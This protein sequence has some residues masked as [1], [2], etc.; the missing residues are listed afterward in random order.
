MSKRSI[1]LLGTITL[2]LFPVPTFVGLYWFE[3]ILP[4]EIFEF[5]NLT[6][7][8]LIL[9]IQLGIVYAFLAL[10]FMQ[11]RIFQEMPTRVEHLVRSMNLNLFD[12]FFLSVCA[13]VGEE[14]LFRSGIQFYLGPIITT[15]IFVAIHGYL[16]PFNWKMSLYGFI[17]L[18]FI[19][20]ISYGYEEFGLWFSIGAHFSY[21]FVLFVVM[22]KSDD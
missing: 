3:D 4:L 11:A 16:N 14:I 5:K 12:C 15:V 8:K 6:T 17:V 22:T 21:D 19:L 2:L 9:G 10:L 1:Y 20:L 13:G 18:P 7:F